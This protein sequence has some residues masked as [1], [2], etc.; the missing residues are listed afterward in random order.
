LSLIDF[1]LPKDH[2]SFLLADT[3]SIFASLPEEDKNFLEQCIIEHP[4]K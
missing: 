3:M 4:A 1:D 2:G